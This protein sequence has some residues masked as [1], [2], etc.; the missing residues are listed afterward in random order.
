MMEKVR[1]LY[2][3]TM[4]DLKIEQLNE[5]KISQDWHT[6]NIVLI[7]LVVILIILGLSLKKLFSLTAKMQALEKLNKINHRN[8]Q[9]QME[10]FSG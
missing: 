8:I 2:D 10:E 4:Y 5:W 6:L 9:I 7:I 1:C 3:N